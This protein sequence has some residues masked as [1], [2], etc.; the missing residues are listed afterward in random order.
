MQIRPTVLSRAE[1]E[2]V[3]KAGLS[4][5][6]IGSD[7]A[8]TLLA[9]RW[10]MDAPGL[11]AECAGRGRLLSLEDIEHWLSDR[12]GQPID[13][14]ELGFG[15]DQADACLEWAAAQGR[16][17]PTLAAVVRDQA[18]ELIAKCQKASAYR[19]N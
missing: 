10:P 9:A 13:P 1:Y 6:G 2:A 7:V 14:F 3:I 19:G 5:Q 15:P 16:G 18:P 17:R 11:L 12:F 8:D 4:H